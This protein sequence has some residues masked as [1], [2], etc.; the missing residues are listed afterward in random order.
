M[1]AG[2]QQYTAPLRQRT[3]AERFRPLGDRILVRPDPPPKMMG[4]LHVPESHQK[5]HQEAKGV[6]IAMGPGM[7]MANG[8]RWPMPDIPIGGR[9]VFHKQGVVPV[10][11]DGETYILVRDDTS[12]AEEIL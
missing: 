9:I 10:V 8:N 4:G 1:T 5:A 7:L 3:Q 11:L 2:Q 12:F 6:V